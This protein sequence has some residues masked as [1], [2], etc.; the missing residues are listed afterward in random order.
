MNPSIY[1]KTIELDYDFM[2]KR[3]VSMG[4]NLFRLLYKDYVPVKLQYKN[5]EIDVPDNL[6]KIITRY[7][8]DMS[9]NS[10]MNLRKT[11]KH[12]QKGMT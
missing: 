10:F 3:S 2:F 9:A 5:V 6:E 12:L 11:R 7:N 1:V 8:P 4:V